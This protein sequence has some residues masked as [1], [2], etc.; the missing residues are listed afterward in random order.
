MNPALTGATIADW[1]G[2]LNMRSQWWGGSIQPYYTVTASMEKKLPYAAEDHNYWGLGG[3]VVSDQSNG[4]LL[5]NNYFSFSAAYHLR[6]NETG[7]DILG[8]GFTGTYANRILDPG[9]FQFQSQL[10]SMGF[11]RDI[12]ANDPITIQKCNYTDVNAGLYYTSLNDDHIITVG[13][14]L[15]HAASPK[16]GAYNNSQYSIPR[17]NILHASAWIR[18]GSANAI[19]ISTLAEYQGGYSIYTLG[20]LFKLGIT[21]ELLRSVNLGVW[22]RFGDAIYPYFGLETKRWT[23]GFSYDFVNADISNYASVQSM[24]LS[25]MWQFGRETADRHPS[26]GVLMY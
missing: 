15:F 1:R 23:A 4:G 13:G 14:A 5:K 25:F 16:E 21:D 17:K 12:P 2:G 9:K 20:G 26:P 18:S 8:A 6:L 19:H 24:E 3:M 11:Q 7:R 22:D 10:G